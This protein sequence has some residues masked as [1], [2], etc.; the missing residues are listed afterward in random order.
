VDLLMAIDDDDDGND[1][2][3][4]CAKIQVRRNMSVQNLKF[5]HVLAYTDDIYGIKT[6]KT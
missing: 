5:G 1:H 3:Y 4:Y 2:I 6:F